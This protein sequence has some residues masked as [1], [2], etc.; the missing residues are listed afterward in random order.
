M[1]AECSHVEESSSLLWI[2][3]GPTTFPPDY[4]LSSPKN[5]V[6]IDVTGKQYRIQHRAD[7]IVHDNPKTVCYT[8]RMKQRK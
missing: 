4:R 2:H 6:C 5:V 8:E 1:K 3:R 7:R